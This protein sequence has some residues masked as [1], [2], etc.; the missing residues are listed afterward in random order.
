MRDIVS[1]CGTLEK[2]LKCGTVPHKAGHLV[3]LVSHVERALLYR[4]GGGL[5]PAG[6]YWYNMSRQIT[7]IQW[8]LLSDQPF[9]VLKLARDK[10]FP[11]YWSFKK[12]LCSAITVWARC[13][14]NGQSIWVNFFHLFSHVPGVL[15]MVASA[16]ED[17]D[18]LWC[19]NHDSFPFKKPLM[20]AQV[21]MVF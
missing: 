20:E 17:S 21:R 10:R 14:S 16:T 9:I 13:V 15:L 6:K 3:T 5:P 19:I 1:I 2:W 7:E 11:L 12:I 8:N 4:S 18:L